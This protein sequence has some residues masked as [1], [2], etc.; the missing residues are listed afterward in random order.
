[1][2]E[3]SEYGWYVKGLIM[4]FIP[5]GLFGLV[6][7]IVG[8]ILKN[9]LGLILILISITIIIFFLWPG[10]GMMALNITLQDEFDTVV[11]R[12]PA[13]GKLESPRILDVGCGTGRTAIQL[14]KALKNGGHLYGIDIYEKLAISGNALE[15]V[16][17]NARLEGVEEKSTFQFGSATEIPF[18]KNTFDIVNVSSVLHEIHEEGGKEKALNEIHRVLKP[19][20][21]LYLGEWN[22]ASWQTIVFMGLFLFVFKSRKFWEDLIISKNFKI[23]NYEN[24][25]GYGI[26]EI[27]KP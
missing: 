12:M 24:F 14:A 23:L 25:G 17:R 22:R 5:I 9:I 19:G 15:T 10:L 26:F 7:L 11:L 3:K 13:L 27:E 21:Y 16:N 4:T 1:M 18:E 2:E 6:L 20:G 8:V